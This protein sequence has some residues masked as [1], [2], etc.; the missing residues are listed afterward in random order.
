MVVIKEGKR[1]ILLKL[2]LLLKQLRYPL[3]IGSIAP[4]SISSIRERVILVV[5]VV[6]VEEALN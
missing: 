1:D 5:V 2:A 6:F 3:S 4:S